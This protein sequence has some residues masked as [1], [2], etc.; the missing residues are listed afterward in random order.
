MAASP[1]I[2]DLPTAEL[3]VLGA[4]IATGGEALDDL[5]LRADD[6]NDARH[7]ALFDLMLAMHETGQHIDPVTLS[8]ADPNNSAFFWSLTDQAPFRHAVNAYA[9]IVAA[10]GMHR[11]LRGVAAGILGLSPEQS[12][13]W[14]LE[15]SQE[16]LDGAAG[17][18]KAKVR[19][20]SDILPGVLERLRT[21]ATFVPSP[22]ESLNSLIGGF[23]PG[24]V[25]VIAARPGVG[26]TVIAAQIAAELAQRGLVS[27]SSLEMSED[28]L[29]SRLIA[30]RL[31]IA[32]NKVKDNHLTDYDW[33]VLGSRI[34]E[35]EAL[36]IAI[37]DRSS[38]SGV[39][40][41]AHAKA[42]SRRGEL[43]GVVVDYMQLMST[44]SKLE[45]HLQVSEFSRQMKVMAK[46]FKVPVIAL[47]QLNR[48][49]E[50]RADGVPKLSDLRESGA[51]EQ[52][53]DV[54][55]LLRREE[56]D[57]HTFMN[58]NESIWLDVAK[59]RHGETGEVELSW[60]GRYSRA[61]EWTS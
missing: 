53:A 27:F 52:D 49:S 51:I 29:V 55:I 25:Y 35:L 31:S 50:S 17:D 38:V 19:M 40:V 23:R 11:R 4:V 3:A 16:L 22:W 5:A 30:E 57:G 12:V 43:V 42:V 59:N 18:A 8:S 9:E 61:V 37:D 1:T 26:K 20:V 39:E 2:G 28:E 58:P 7:A 21:N 13:D 14:M 48:Q 54:V 34:G 47:S 32:V 44:K 24:A 36:N 33:G 45:R 15:R 41:R 60:Q 56:N 6:F 10:H 46:D